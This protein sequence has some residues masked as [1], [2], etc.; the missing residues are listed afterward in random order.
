MNLTRAREI[1]LL[2]MREHNLITNKPFGNWSFYWD[3][4]S[5]AKLGACIFAEKT[6]KFS[7]R[8][9]AYIDE[10][11]FRNTM[12][13]EIAHALV[14]TGHGHDDVWKKKC[15]EIGGDGLEKAEIPRIYKGEFECAAC[16]VVAPS[17]HSSGHGVHTKCNRIITFRKAK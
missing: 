11:R 16:K 8:Y 2:M 12:L 7:Q 6:I 1:G 10:A 5:T 15:L 3:K 17:K 9:M 13:H 4:S 14:G